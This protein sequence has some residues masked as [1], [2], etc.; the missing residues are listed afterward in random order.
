MHFS[1]FNKSYQYVLYDINMNFGIISYFTTNST[2]CIGCHLKLLLLN[3]SNPTNY[4]AYIKIQY[5]TYRL[6]IEGYNFER[7][8]GDKREC[9]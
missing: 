7:R 5:A 8:N 2:S 3:V 4:R 9:A 1:F 6:E